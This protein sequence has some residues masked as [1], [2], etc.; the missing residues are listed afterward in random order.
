MDILKAQADLAK[1]HAETMR[2]LD[3]V[4]KTRQAEQR[5]APILTA[6]A[7]LAIGTGFAV[8]CVQFAKLFLH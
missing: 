2:L 7:F 8:V 4:Q 3:D 1:L 5:W 6:S